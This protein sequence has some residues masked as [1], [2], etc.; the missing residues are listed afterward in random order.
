MFGSLYACTL[1][2]DGYGKKWLFY[3]ILFWREKAL[4]LGFDWI[5]YIQFFV[6]SLKCLALQTFSVIANLETMPSAN[7]ET[8]TCAHFICVA[9]RY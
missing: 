4:G 5:S 2:D 6:E 7:Q 3:S 8:H 9:S 1:L